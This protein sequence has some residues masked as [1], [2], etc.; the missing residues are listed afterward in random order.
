MESPRTLHYRRI[1]FDREFNRGGKA[2]ESI[3]GR[4]W[5]GRS[6]DAPH[7]YAYRRI[8][9]YARASSRRPAGTIVDYACGPGNLLLRL[10]REFPRAR[11]IGV[12]GSSM[13]LKAALER[14]TRSAGGA[15]RRVR[16]IRTE[17]PDPRLPRAVA[18]MVVYA[19]PNMLHR[20]DQKPW[21]SGGRT[22]PDDVAV[23]RHQARAREPDPEDETIDEDPDSLFESLLSDRAI[24]RNIR[25]MLRRGGI[26]VRV[27][28]SDALR[29]ELTDLTQQRTAFEEGSL[30]GTYGGRRPARF[31]RL[32]R[33]TY[34]RSRVV[35]DVYHQTRQPD[36]RKGGYMIS[37]LEA[38]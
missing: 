21:R 23:A 19:F 5:H 32:L 33:S 30:Q 37:V 2:Y 10:V 27:E 35:E 20:P 31:F 16:F 1:N 11:F 38:I 29:T 13:L 26:C 28:Y 9:R 34:S 6:E 36:D 22:P 18:D 3:V 4:W 12:D 24:G 17:L 7:A 15:E 25:R 14:L 8:A